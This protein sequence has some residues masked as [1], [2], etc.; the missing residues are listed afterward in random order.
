MSANPL[1]PKPDHSPRLALRPRKAAEAL[2]ISER[3]LW[4]WTKRRGIPCIKVGKTVLYDVVALQR[5]LSEQSTPAPMNLAE[6]SE[7]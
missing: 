6:R 3:T 2:G 1:F 4:D 5:W 7:V